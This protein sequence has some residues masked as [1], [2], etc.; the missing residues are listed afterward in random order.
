M[1][2]LKFGDLKTGSGIKRGNEI[3]RMCILPRMAIDRD[4]FP[5]SKGD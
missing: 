1:A 4:T 3:V 2:R 5:A